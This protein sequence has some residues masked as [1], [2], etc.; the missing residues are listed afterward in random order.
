MSSIYTFSLSDDFGSSFVPSQFHNEIENSN[1]TTELIGININ[2]D[3]IEVK[4]VSD[5]SASEETEL[6][7]LVSNHVSA[8]DTKEFIRSY[9]Y[10]ATA[11]TSGNYT[12]VGFIRF[13]GTMALG[14]GI[15]IFAM[16]YMGSG[17]SYDIRILNANNSKVIAE[18]NFTNTSVQQHNLDA[19]SDKI[20]FGRSTW[21]IQIRANGLLGQAAYLTQIFIKR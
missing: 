9:T 1:I 7:N 14:T 15:K 3:V 19:D 11:R 20:T 21:Q 16:S 4:F 10:E 5:L 2:G 8:S 18:K 13:E 6:N 17:T 12:N